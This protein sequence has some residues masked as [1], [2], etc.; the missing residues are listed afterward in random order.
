M[1]D[2]SICIQFWKAFFS[3]LGVRTSFELN[4]VAWDRQN[5]ATWKWSSAITLQFGRNRS[6]EIGAFPLRCKM[7]G[8]S[9]DIQF[10]NACFSV[11]GVRTWFVFNNVAWDRRNEAT[12]KC[13]SVITLQHGR[14]LSEKIGAFPPY[15]KMQDSN[16]SIHF[17]CRVFSHAFASL[18]QFYSRNSV[19]GHHNDVICQQ[20]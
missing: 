16:I 18:L 9:I 1:Q 4:N 13:S 12:R 2:N 8:S 20:S 11:L 14:N 7:Q 17:Q 3:V 15:C 5:E 19:S 10:W 6:G